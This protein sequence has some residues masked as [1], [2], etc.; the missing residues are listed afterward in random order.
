MSI[1]I[2][3][4]DERGVAA[5][6]QLTPSMCNPKVTELG[7]KPADRRVAGLKRPSGSIQYRQLTRSRLRLVGAADGVT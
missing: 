2:P 4:S 1:A 3:T 6:A 5:A 7:G